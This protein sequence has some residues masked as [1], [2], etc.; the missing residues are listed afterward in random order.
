[1]SVVNDAVST[2]AT[3]RLAR[4]EL[5]NALAWRAAVGL[6][7]AEMAESGLAVLVTLMSTPDAGGSFR[8]EDGR[9]WR[10]GAPAVGGAQ[11]AYPVRR[12]AVDLGVLTL[13][14]ARAVGSEEADAAADISHGLAISVS[15]ETAWNRLERMDRVAE[16]AELVLG[17][18]HDMAQP[19][20]AIAGHVAMLDS[21]LGGAENLDAISRA[22]ERLGGHIDRMRDYTRVTPISR[23]PVDLRDLA[24]R[25]VLLTGAA[26]R[27]TV[28]IHGPSG[29][30]VHGDTAR[31]EQVVVNLIANAF[32]AGATVVEIVVGDAPVPNIE[33][34]DDG[35]GVP[36]DMRERIFAPF[37]TTRPDGIGLGLAISARI[38]T[39]HGG[40]IEVGENAVRGAIFRVLLG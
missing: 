30:V 1:M 13:W 31:L 9:E 19:L 34:R 39:E 17:S 25:G 37:F 29:I 21:G 36:P 18:A 15:R 7:V 23:L 26:M 2:R 5:T 40:R 27:R 4:L 32:G 3:T 24:R 16:A 38:V 28:T 22:V 14:P 33:V 12:G 10:A 35:P 6:T 20:Q 11:A 8:M